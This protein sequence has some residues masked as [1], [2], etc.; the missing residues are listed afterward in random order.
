MITKISNLFN[1]SFQISEV[2]IIDVVETV[3]SE[4]EIW[5]ELRDRDFAIKAEIETR[6]LTFLWW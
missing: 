6:D 3:T 4:T 2:C 1:T 5:L